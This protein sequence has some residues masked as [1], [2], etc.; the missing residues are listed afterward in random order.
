MYI[1]LELPVEELEKQAENMK[2][3]LKTVDHSLVFRFIRS[4]KHLFEPFRSRDCQE[5]MNAIIKRIVNIR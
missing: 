2:Y 4:S 3:E 1:V 5:I